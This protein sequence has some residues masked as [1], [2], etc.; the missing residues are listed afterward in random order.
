MIIKG[1]YLLF[2]LFFIEPNQYLLLQDWVFF[3]FYF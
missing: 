3:L 2:Y 1:A